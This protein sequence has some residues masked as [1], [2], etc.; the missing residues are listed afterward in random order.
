MSD[1]QIV[2]LNLLAKALGELSYEQILT[3]LEVSTGHF[4]LTL[5]SGAKY[6]FSAWRGVWDHLRIDPQ[7]IKKS[8]SETIS[9]A[10]FFIDAQSEVEMD[11]I[12]LG[13]FLEEMH[14]NL[15]S[16]ITLLNKQKNV[17]ATSMSYWSGEKVQAYLNG[18]PKILLSK[19]RVGWGSHE[20]QNYAPESERAVNLF[21]VAVKKESLEFSFDDSVSMKSLLEE[22]L[23]SQ[24]MERF[25][26]LLDEKKMKFD[27]FNYLPLHPW[28]WDRFVK[29]QYQAT[30]ANKE[31]IELGL[32]GDDYIPQISIRTL[33]NI[34]RPEKLDVKLP[35]TILNTSAIRGIPSRYISVGAKLSR[36]ILSLCH[37]DA[38][39]NK[40][41]TDVLVEMGGASLEHKAF[42][43]IKN[44]PY[45]YKEYLGAIW[46]E[47]TC[48]KL[49]ENE[50]GILT[51]SLFYQD[52]NKKSLIGAYIERSKLSKEEWLKD[53][54]EVVVIPLYHLQVKYGLGLV[55]HGQNIILKMQN[56]RP[57]GVILKDFQ[58][59]LRL[60]NDSVLITRDDFKEVASKL[61]KM[62]KEYLIHDL[63]T[64]HFVT[65]LRFISEVMEESDGLR[66]VEFYRI[67]AEVIKS[68][69]EEYS[70]PKELNFLNEKIHRVLV[71][72]VRFKIGYG[73]SSER[74]KPA[75]GQDLVN[76]LFM[77]LKS[78]EEING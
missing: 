49:K 65:V 54:F 16:D 13:N 64:G 17:S 62:P 23:N 12:V 60:S 58:G 61:D 28:Q 72:K 71:N 73:D 32:F 56:Y 7:S 51:G 15:Y 30:I 14:N 4:E 42:A 45:R 75:V 29:I 63:L 40:L 46:R 19:G 8:G 76:P 50:Q 55:A 10:D 3:P 44:A 22:S 2:N 37:E 35:L 77:A 21:W 69:I 20:L 6:T 11:D 33:S 18:H 67:L 68:Y 25:F 59:D 43:K 47:S 34:S 52:H 39:L 5:S 24:E 70:V 27:H 66:E 57:V 9:A 36:S 41:G 1:W 26:D 53:Y 38:L 78:S 48:S 31:M 74:P